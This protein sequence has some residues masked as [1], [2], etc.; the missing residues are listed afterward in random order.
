MDKR[1]SIATPT[2]HHAATESAVEGSVH[3]ETGPEEAAV[4]TSTLMHT[5]R[6]LHGQ[7]VIRTIPRRP[8]KKLKHKRHAL[9]STLHR[10]HSRRGQ[11]HAAIVPGPLVAVSLRGRISQ[12]K[13]LPKHRERELTILHC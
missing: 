10:L 5:L 6:T 11:D 13:L 1:V 4:M 9:P 7:C 3:E 2:K 8:R 12:H